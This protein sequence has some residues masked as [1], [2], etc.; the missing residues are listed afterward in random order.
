MLAV[1]AAFVAVVTG[2]GA[3]VASPTAEGDATTVKGT[4]VDPEKNPVSAVKLSVTNSEAVTGADGKTFAVGEFKA[5]VVTGGDG[6]W[7][8]PLPG[9]GRYDVTLDEA[10]LPEGISLANPDQ[11]T[12]NVNVLPGQ[13]ATAL[14]RLA[15]G[16]S[17]DSGGSSTLDRFLQLT[18]DGLL[19]GL[20]IALAAIGLSLI[21]GTTGL[22]NFS[23]GELVTLG[24][25]TAYFFSSIVGLPFILAAA[26]AVVV[27]GLLAF[28]LSTPGRTAMSTTV[29]LQA[30]CPKAPVSSRTS[31]A[32]ARLLR[33]T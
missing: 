22:T 26:V 12:R 33:P 14:F 30:P 21:F 25:L 13:S 11:V 29:P 28:R 19:F 8:A 32:P 18:V 31:G 15:S 24:A 5:S 23:H 3:A 4:I 9:G 17:P 27:C 1:L 7:A 6:K 2:A 10:S 20:T 16:D